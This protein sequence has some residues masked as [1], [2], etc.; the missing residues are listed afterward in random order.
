MS[1][2]HNAEGQLG[3]GWT[4]SGDRSPN[5]F[6]AV[7]LTALGSRTV[8]KVIARFAHVIL[9]ANDG[10]TYGFG[11]NNVQHLVLADGTTTNR[12]APV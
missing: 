7:D 4:P 3:T 6:T 9:V 11:L 10:T 1:S 8:S 12:P 2:G 5:A